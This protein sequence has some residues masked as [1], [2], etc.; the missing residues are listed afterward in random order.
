[1]FRSST[2][3]PI[4][5]LDCEWVTQNEIRHPVALLQ[6]SDN[7]GLCSLIRLSKLRTISSS[8]SVSLIQIIFVQYNK[9]N[10]FTM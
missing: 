5:G 7:N 4:I 10:L 2:D 3:L 1:M 8:L 6:L 9:Y